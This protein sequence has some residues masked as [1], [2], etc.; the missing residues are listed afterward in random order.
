ME[1][2]R[3]C[4]TDVVLS[5]LENLSERA[6]TKP[7][8]QVPSFRLAIKAG[9]DAV[10]SRRQPRSR[11]MLPATLKL[12]CGIAHDHLRRLPGLKMTAVAAIRKDVRGLV[13]KGSRHL[14]SKIPRYIQRLMGK[15]TATCPEPDGDVSPRRLSGVDLSYIAQGETALQRALSIL[16][17]HAGWQAETMLDTGTTV[18]SASFPG[19]GKVF[20]AEVVLAVPVGQLHR[21]LFERMEQMPRWNPALS[22]VKV[23]QR[24]GMDTLVTHEIT[25]PSPGNLVGQRD[26]VSVRHR[27]KREMTIYLVG[28]ATHIEPLPS[29]EG[30]IRAE[31]RLSCIVLQ[32][33]AG[34]AG[35]TRFTWLLSMDLKGWIPTSVMDRVL[36]QSQA[37]FIKHLRRHLS[38]TACP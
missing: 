4:L 22:R 7:L 12:C 9:R 25:A 17:Q 33:L 16:Q 28:T 23:L 5:K 2:E 37:D 31:S 19:L 18:S 35:R 14:P 20:R 30:C 36:P 21:E 29:Q 26:F 13:A 15:E 34:G 11:A 32:P 8:L 27:W 1:G 10:C 38:A 24:V 6:W 3:S